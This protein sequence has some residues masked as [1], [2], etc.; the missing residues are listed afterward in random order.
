[1]IRICFASTLLFLAA[2]AAPTPHF[3]L[4]D[5][6]ETYQEPAGL[7]G[8]L[9]VQ[10]YPVG[11]IA[12][13]VVMKDIGESDVLTFRVAQNETDRDGNGQQDDEKGGGPG[14]GIGVRR[15][16]TRARTG[17]MK[18]MRLDIWDLDIDWISRP[19]TP[20]ELRGKS[21]VLVL[22]PTIEYGYAAQLGDAWR[23]ET[24]A[25]LGAEINIDTKGRDVGEGAILL[26]GFSLT[27]GF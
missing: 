9:D 10:V 18:G 11:Y 2:C 8:G 12:G 4:Q 22:Q 7:R 14:V 16:D 24:Y 17:W 25:A 21:D 26:L 3:D 27:L 1:M 15:Y 5:S 20:M 6:P 23:L 19:G 13:A